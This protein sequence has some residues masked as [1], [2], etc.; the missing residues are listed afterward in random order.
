MN[1]TKTAQ[2]KNRFRVHIKTLLSLRRAFIT[3]MESRGFTSYN[4]IPKFVGEKEIE[5]D[6]CIE[7]SDETDLIKIKTR[8]K[9]ALE[10]LMKKYNDKWSEI[11][12]FKSTG[13]K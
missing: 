8:T 11:T 4:S 6:F 10:N 5:M 3:S 13:E 7:F 2:V 1:W 9:Y 12:Y